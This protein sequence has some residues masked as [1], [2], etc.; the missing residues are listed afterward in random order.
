MAVPSELSIE[1]IR[2]FMLENGGKV[3]NHE[4]VKHFKGFLTDPETRVEARNLFKEYVNTV[5]TIRNEEGEKYLILKKKYRNPAGIQSPVSTPL[6]SGTSYDS[7]Q[8]MSPSG[9]FS[10]S[11]ESLD[12][13]SPSRQP[14]P[15]R[16]PP[17]PVASPVRSIAT[18]S[19]MTSPEYASPPP[20]PVRQNSV[21]SHE[22]PIQRAPQ[23]IVRS[24]S[25]DESI[26]DEVVE[27]TVIHAPPP[28]PPRRKSTD[29]LKLENKENVPDTDVVDAEEQKISVK[30]RMLKFN[31][32]AT[33]TDLKAHP[34]AN[35][36]KFERVCHF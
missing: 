13:V 31:R 35:K 11:Q 36:K 28:V 26:N 10:I 12:V 21:P 34:V 5:A 30:E 22:S 14:P 3:T 7:L 9:A 32:L 20:P 33:E 29:K 24:P 18:P 23:D 6:S 15:Y 1:A 25:R 2:V 4:L 16:A 17:P 19:P 8:S 27:E